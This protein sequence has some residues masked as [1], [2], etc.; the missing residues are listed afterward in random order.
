MAAVAQVK[1]LLGAGADVRAT[2][3]A[4]WGMFPAQVTAVQIAEKMQSALGLDRKEIITL[5]AENLKAT[6]AEVAARKKRE[7][8]E[9]A[10]RVAATEKAAA[11]AR[12]AKLKADAEADAQRR[13]ALAELKI[14]EA[15]E[16]E[17]L[18]KEALPPPSSPVK[19]TSPDP[20]A[21]AA[22]ALS[23]QER[24]AK[25]LED[26]IKRLER[27]RQLY[28]LR[29]E[30]AKEKL[31]A[32]AAQAAAAADAVEA[33]EAKR[34]KEAAD[35]LARK[36]RE[37]EQAAADAAQRRKAA[38][39]RRKAAEELRKQKTA[40]SPTNLQE[41]STK[42][43]EG[44]A[45]KSL[46]LGEFF[47]EADV[48][49]SGQLDKIEL[50]KALRD[51]LGMELTKSEIDQIVQYA[52][53]PSA[54]DGRRNGLIDYREF[55]S[56]FNTRAPGRRAISQIHSNRTVSGGAR[57]SSRSVSDG[58]SIDPSSR[59]TPAAINSNRSPSS[60]PSKSTPAIAQGEQKTP[61]RGKT[62]QELRKSKQQE[63]AKAPTS[64][65][66]EPGR[67]RGSKIHNNRT[68]SSSPSKWM[69]LNR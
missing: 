41:L 38:A 69:Q 32:Q 47:T 45:R 4:E 12:H 34:R 53:Q 16:R 17:K 3:T 54:G 35:A 20:A 15:A 7:A 61:A 27:D 64:N 10:E 40:E 51:A 59:G 50:G 29:A 24:A 11:E 46:S 5:L 23:Q 52:D 18:A 62:A 67:S 36:K 22:L 65:T 25:E 42:L 57:S 21:V 31:A 49:G 28:E 66:R 48:D 33:E 44:L 68:S 39:E 6:E 2:S 43:H 13:L 26:E 63:T 55:L 1:A 8:E 37:R 60:S 56:A 14:N 58:A 19:Q 9:E 30:E